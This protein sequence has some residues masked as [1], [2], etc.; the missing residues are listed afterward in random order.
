MCVFRRRTVPKSLIDQLG[1]FRRSFSRVIVFLSLSRVAATSQRLVFPMSSALA[2][3]VT[4]LH[5][6]AQIIVRAF[7]VEILR[8][9]VD[10][11]DTIQGLLHRCAAAAHPCKASLSVEDRCTFFAR[12][13]RLG[14]SLMAPQNLSPGLRLILKRAKK[15]AQYAFVETDKTGRL[16]QVPLAL[17]KFAI[18]APIRAKRGVGGFELFD[19]PVCFAR[20]LYAVKNLIN[21]SAE[22]FRR[23]AQEWKVRWINRDPFLALQIPLAVTLATKIEAVA[24]YIPA[25]GPVKPLIKDHKMKIP[26]QEWLDRWSV[27]ST[28]VLPI[29]LVHKATVGPSQPVAG[30]SHCPCA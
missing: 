25:Y 21:D 1:C 16:L 5:P 3:A 15:E 24:G 12:V 23:H 10:A 14:S 8:L 9:P 18:E 29:R 27:Q 28:E 2:D 11:G 20:Q 13:I 7:L 26:V 19:D 30:G 22:V 6:A 17:I 4:V